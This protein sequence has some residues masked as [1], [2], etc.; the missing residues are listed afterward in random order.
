MVGHA[1]ARGKPDRKSVTNTNA[2]FS[3]RFHLF[4]PILQLLTEK[5]EEARLAR[6]LEMRREQWE[7]QAAGVA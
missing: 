2:S 4:I 5:S 1:M 6:E 7:T 3:S